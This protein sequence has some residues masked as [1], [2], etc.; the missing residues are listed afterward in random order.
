MADTKEAQKKGMAKF[1]PMKHRAWINPSQLTTYH[2]EKYEKII[3]VHPSKIINWKFHDRPISEIGDIDALA[4]DIVSVGQQQPCIVRKHPESDQYELIVGER[5][6]RAAAKTNI[7]LKVIV[8]SLSDLDAAMAQSS[9]NDNRKDLSEYAKGMSFAKLIENKI[10]TRKD[11]IESLGRSQ[12]HISALLSYSKMPNEINNAI[13][14]WSKVSPRTAETIVRLSK[15]S[16]RHIRAILSL[17]SLVEKGVVG[18]K[19]L[20]KKVSEILEANFERKPTYQKIYA[21]DGCV[22][23]LIK[24][25]DGCPASIKFPKKIKNLF[26]KGIADKSKIYKSIKNEL[27]NIFSI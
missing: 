22:L 8:R 25:K 1:K 27:E 6:W 15:K 13:K 18:A 5:R 4:K 23:F 16:K 12:Q 3:L 17:S 19:S 21:K 14:D 7:D 26:T 24:E 11:L 9:E 2:D 20:E 10:I